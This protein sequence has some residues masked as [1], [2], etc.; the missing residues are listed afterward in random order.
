MAAYTVR[1][2]LTVGD[3]LVLARDEPPTA[4]ERA[5]LALAA[6]DAEAETVL[7]RATDHRGAGA[8]APLDPECA[9]DTPLRDAAAY[10]WRTWALCSHGAPWQAS[11][12]PTGIVT[13]EGLP[14]ALAALVPGAPEGHVP[15]PSSDTDWSWLITSRV[16]QGLSERG[17][18]VVYAASLPT[19]VR[20]TLRKLAAARGTSISR[21]VAVGDGVDCNEDH[22]G[23]LRCVHLCA[24]GA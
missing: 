17:L 1:A 22:A 14:D 2:C 6:R 13:V 15:M 7:L 3:V 21:I 12:R 19:V 8:A 24:P 18:A 16:K 10:S 23:V 20:I 5:V 4:P 9:A 11:V